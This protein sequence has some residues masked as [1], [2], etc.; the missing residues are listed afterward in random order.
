MHNGSLVFVATDNVDVRAMSKARLGDAQRDTG[1]L[2]THSDR[3]HAQGQYASNQRLDSPLS[4]SKLRNADRL[5]NPAVLPSLAHT[6][7]L[8]AQVTWGMGVRSGVG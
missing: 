8:R 2:I 7:N 4:F 3:A 5:F 6:H 1:G